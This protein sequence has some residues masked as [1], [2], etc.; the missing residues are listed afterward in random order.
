[1]EST[2]SA[3][4]SVMF[5]EILLLPWIRR[6]KQQHL[7]SLSS[8]DATLFLS[9]GGCVLEIQ[10]FCFDSSVGSFLQASAAWTDAA[11]R[12]VEGGQ[13]HLLQDEGK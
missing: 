4:D 6:K 7:K 10:C 5:K 13:P 11:D 3:L 1:M 2:L 12:N 8:T 9:A